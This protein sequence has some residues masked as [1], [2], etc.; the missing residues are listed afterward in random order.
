MTHSILKTI[1]KD[2]VVHKYFADEPCPFGYHEVNSTFIQVSET[3]HCKDTTFSIFFT[4][5][6]IAAVSS[7]VSNIADIGDINFKAGV[8]LS[9][10]LIGAIAAA[11]YNEG[12]HF[13][14]PQHKEANW[15]E[16]K[17]CVT[18]ELVIGTGPIPEESF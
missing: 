16:Y 13:F 3:D 15:Q 14:Y 4:G 18:N 1:V 2:N 9:P 6:G 10:P 8:I 17:T 5:I 11:I 12:C 7:L